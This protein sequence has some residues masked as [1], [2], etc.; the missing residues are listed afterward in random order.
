MSF[1]SPRPT[2]RPSS[3]GLPFDWMEPRR[4]S[5]RPKIDRA[6]R[7]A[8]YR[9]ELEE[10][11]ALLHRLGY[12][13]E[14]TRARPLPAV[15]EAVEQGGPL[16]QLDPVHGLPPGPVDLGPLRGTPRLHPIEGHAGRA[17]AGSRAR[18]G[19]GHRALL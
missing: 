17:R 14:R 1:P 5:E 12:S 2:S 10:R 4:T 9:I 13:R 8:M 19:K 16:F 3:T 6:R 11:A 18:R 15:A 7:E